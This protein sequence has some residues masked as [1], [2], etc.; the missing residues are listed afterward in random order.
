MGENKENNRGQCVVVSLMTSSAREF[1][2]PKRVREQP[3]RFPFVVAIFHRVNFQRS[4]SSPGKSVPSLF[5]AKQFHST[6]KDTRL[7]AFLWPNF[8]SSTPVH[9]DIT[10]QL[11]TLLL[12]PFF[13]SFSLCKSWFLSKNSIETRLTVNT[14]DVFLLLWQRLI[15]FSPFLSMGI[16]RQIGRIVVA[17]FPVICPWHWRFVTF[18]SFF[19]GLQ[20]AR[21][22]RIRIAKASS[23]AA[24]V[25]KK[26]A[27]EARLAAQESGLQLDDNYKEE[28]I[29]ELQHHHLLRCLE[30][31]TVS[32]LKI[33][34]VACPL[35]RSYPPRLSLINNLHVSFFVSRIHQ[36]WVWTLSWTYCVR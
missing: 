6:W 21:L 19:F 32:L 27:A 14:P 35:T 29:F 7:S 12:F 31:T 33:V 24:F 20:K 8:S 9:R 2:S 18:A 4:S 10:P 25:S 3:M 23:G 17:K 28:D 15:V 26:K 30:K 1:A 11:L 22:A 16:Q 36:T 5:S 13:L 34:H